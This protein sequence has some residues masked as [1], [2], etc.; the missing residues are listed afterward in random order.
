MESLP[1][2]LLTNIFLYL[3]NSDLLHVLLTCSNWKA[4]ADNENC[5]FTR[6]KLNYGCSKDCSCCFGAISCGCKSNNNVCWKTHFLCVK[7]SVAG[8]MKSKRHN[9]SEHRCV[10]YLRLLLWSGHERPLYQPHIYQVLRDIDFKRFYSCL[11]QCGSIHAVQRFTDFSDAFV[12]YGVIPKL[13]NLCKISSTN[14]DR[15]VHN[16]FK[17]LLQLFRDPYIVVSLMDWG[18]MRLRVDEIYIEQQIDRLG[19]KKGPPYCDFAYYV[20]LT[21]KIETLR[22]LLQLGLNPNYRGFHSAAHPY[23]I[24]GF[25]CDHNSINCAR[26]LLDSGARLSDGYKELCNYGTITV[27]NERAKRRKCF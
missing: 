8:C 7:R 27:A 25:C 10:S 22:K 18:T 13:I 24:A 12:E 15:A 2:E 20:C 6:C 1:S 26:L 21:K 3:D 4:I 19:V 23:G 9:V 16:H 11:A 17:A 5:W 14:K